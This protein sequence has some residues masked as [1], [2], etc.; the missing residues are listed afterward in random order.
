M[1]I[2]TPGL[3][4]IGLWENNAGLEINYGDIEELSLL[5]KFKNCSHKTEPE[6]AIKKAIE[7]GLI[8]ERRFNN[9]LKMKKEQEFQD[10]K[11]GAL[12]RKREETKRI[13]KLIRK[14]KK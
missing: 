11:I 13:S 8:E 1:I 7:Q 6:C 12:Q 2:D 5:C 9:Y 14:M 4:E 10:D 3:R